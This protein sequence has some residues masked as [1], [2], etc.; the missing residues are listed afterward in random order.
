MNSLSYSTLLEDWESESF[1]VCLLATNQVNPS[2]DMARLEFRNSDLNSTIEPN[3]D[4]KAL[5]RI[6]FPV[7]RG[8]FAYLSDNWGVAKSSFE[9]ISLTL[10][11]SLLQPRKDDNANLRLKSKD[12]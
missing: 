6:L 10:G 12:A 1:M 3:D 5:C 11:K 7:S 4:V 8:S 9:L 2:P